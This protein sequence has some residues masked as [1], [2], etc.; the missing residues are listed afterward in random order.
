M[1]KIISLILFLALL[2][3]PAALF[4]CK[5]SNNPG[6]TVV[7]TSENLPEEDAIIIAENGTCNYKVIYPSDT[8]GAVYRI[9]GEVCNGIN[10]RYNLSIE[11]ATDG[12]ESAPNEILIGETN[13]PES[14]TA[15]SMLGNKDYIVTVI[16]KKLVLY[17]K[18]NSCYDNLLKILFGRFAGERFSI[19]L[20]FTYSFYKDGIVN[21]DT[22]N[23]GNEITFINGTTLTLDINKQIVSSGSYG[24][25]VVL[26][27]NEE[28]YGRIIYSYGHGQTVYISDDEGETFKSYKGMVD[29]THWRGTTFNHVGM[30]SM[31]ELPVDMG[32]F[33]KGTVFECGTS[34]NGPYGEVS[35]VDNG[36]KSTIHIYY[37]L[38]AG[39]SF[40]LLGYID[41]ERNLGLGV[42]EPY[43]VYE[44]S[45]NRVY[46]FYS[47]DS[48][49]EHDQKIVYKYSTNLINWV[50]KDGTVDINDYKKLKEDEY[51]DPFEA[52]SCSNSTMRPGMPILTKMGNGEW[53]LVYELYG[54]G[55]GFKGQIHAKKTTRLDDWGKIS[56]YGT[57][58]TSVDGRTLEQAPYCAWT[59]VGGE[60][61]MLIVSARNNQANEQLSKHKCDILIS[62]D[63]GEH[64]TSIENPFDGTVRLSTGYSL[65]HPVILFS[66]DG[67]TM[68]YFNQPA[69]KNATAN[70]LRM[71]RYIIETAD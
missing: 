8:F 20:D 54:G 51:P 60:N 65:R 56:D 12:S 16:N 7:T 1:K 36:V 48:D 52:V 30:S 50:G 45:T 6:S 44:E 58:I 19:P 71:A 21:E 11:P 4:S 29:N 47:D 66:P 43:M 28:H 2:I 40:T 34:M 26:Q 55:S 15:K 57:R 3:T 13:R 18:A 49:P 35:G 5:S 39:E 27:Y 22:G 64:F 53:Y 70:E 62:F 23:L 68:Y 61:G 31:F 42:W 25:G 59:P 14:E 33:P 37:S 41:M 10:D 69:N 24:M 17:S 67:K 46:C 32:D 9:A 38:D 63:Y